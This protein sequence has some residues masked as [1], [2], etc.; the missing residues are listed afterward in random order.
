MAAARHVTFER[1]V[2]QGA[3]VSPGLP[4][5]ASAPFSWVELRPRLCLSGPAWG[6]CRRRAWESRAVL[7]PGLSSSGS[8]GNIRPL[9][10]YVLL[11]LCFA[12]SFPSPDP[13]MSSVL[14][15]LAPLGIVLLLA[16]CASMPDAADRTQQDP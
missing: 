15:R 6:C 2:F 10:V 12:P 11:C 3:E 4:A 5:T 16:G 13:L 14:R 1:C 9:R 8:P 7:D